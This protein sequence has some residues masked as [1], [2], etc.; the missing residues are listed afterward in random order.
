VKAEEGA[1]KAKANSEEGVTSTDAEE[2]TEPRRM[3]LKKVGLMLKT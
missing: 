2:V 3:L 1:E